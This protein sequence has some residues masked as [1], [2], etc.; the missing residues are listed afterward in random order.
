ME[1]SGVTG[2]AEGCLL[3]GGQAGADEEARGVCEEEPFMLSADSRAGDPAIES[4]ASLKQKTEEV[5]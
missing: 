5:D 2:P 3:L 1:V 4:I